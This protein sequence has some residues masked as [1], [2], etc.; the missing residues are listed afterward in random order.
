MSDLDPREAEMDGL[1]R[2]SMAVPVPRLSQDF[3]QALS[4][5]LRRR[6]EPPHPLGPILLA[7][8][9]FVSLVTSIVVMRGQGLDW[10]AIA[11]MTLGPLAV[12]ELSRRLRRRPVGMAAR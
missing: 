2:R 7:G 6:S 11:V 4:R 1:L 8:Y 3:H 5:K 10:V 12:L 9:G